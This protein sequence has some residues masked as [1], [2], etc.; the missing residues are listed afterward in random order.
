M[1]KGGIFHHAGRKST[2]LLSRFWK[3]I[4]LIARRNPQS[5]SEGSHWCFLHSY[6]LQIHFYKHKY[7][8]NVYQLILLPRRHEEKESELLRTS[9]DTRNPSDEL[10]RMEWN[11]RRRRWYPDWRR[12]IWIPNGFGSRFGRLSRGL[13]YRTPKESV[14][15][16]FQQKQTQQ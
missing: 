3:L 10:L 9:S 14:R 5:S 7:I 12:S 4:N 1:L 11:G 2:W 6:L 8:Q 15:K 16:V 13:K